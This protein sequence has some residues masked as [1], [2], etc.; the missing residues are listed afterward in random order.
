VGDALAA[1][2]LGGFKHLRSK[3][4]LVRSRGDGDD[5]VVLSG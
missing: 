5:V 2:H 3:R 4:M 1:S